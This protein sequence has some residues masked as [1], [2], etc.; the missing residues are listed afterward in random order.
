MR[1]PE[2]G[3]GHI[4]K[5]AETLQILKDIS[6]NRMPNV[7]DLLKQSS[8][9]QVAAAQAA[10]SPPTAGQV[11]TTVAG[12][13]NTTPQ[14]TKPP[15]T[16]PQMVDAESS[17]QPPAKDAPPQ[18][19]SKSNSKPGLRLPVTTVMGSGSKQAQ[20]PAAQKLDDAVTAQQDLL[21]EFEKIADE[22][23]KV[24]ANLEGSTLLKRLKAASRSNT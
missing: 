6:A 22:L 4:E 21:A 18:E 14:D 2:F 19:P 12:K 20:P 5:W 10:K 13:S 15:A 7:A 9:A 1:N 24:L 8:Q 17:Q 23:N 3:V 16:V 11:R